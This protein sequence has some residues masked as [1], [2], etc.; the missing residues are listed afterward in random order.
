[1][2]VHVECG[3][4]I[5]TLGRRMSDK[6]YIIISCEIQIQILRYRPVQFLVVVHGVAVKFER[7]RLRYQ[8]FAGRGPRE[9]GAFERHRGT[10]FT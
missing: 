3:N 7:G 4:S 5:R 10:V 1:M 9:Y 2:L 6:S 8:L